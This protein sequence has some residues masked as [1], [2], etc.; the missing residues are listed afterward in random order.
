[1]WETDQKQITKYRM[2]CQVSVFAMEKI[3]QVKEI[4]NGERS[5]ILG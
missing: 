3:K 4:E 2:S 1:M 5:T